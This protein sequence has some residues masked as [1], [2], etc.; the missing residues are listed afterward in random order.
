MIYVAIIRGEDKPGRVELCTS[1]KALS[2][3]TGIPLSTLG[4][5]FGRKKKDYYEHMSPWI[6]IFV[7]DRVT[8]QKRPQ[9][10]RLR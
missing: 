1:Q 9:Y 2:D 6:E 7:A 8:R 5:H 10:N 3:L 4:Y